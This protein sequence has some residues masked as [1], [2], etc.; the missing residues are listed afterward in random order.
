MEVDKNKYP[1]YYENDTKWDEHHKKEGLM[2][3]KEFF[4]SNKKGGFYEGME[5][6]GYE[7]VSLKEEFDNLQTCNYCGEFETNCRC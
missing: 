7:W 2:T 5:W 1:N 3:N 6:N 4:T